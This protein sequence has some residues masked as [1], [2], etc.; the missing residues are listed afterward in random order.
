MRA[1]II[2]PPGPALRRQFVYLHTERFS[3]GRHFPH[4]TAC[5]MLSAL[6]EKLKIPPTP[7]N[8]VTYRLSRICFSQTARPQNLQIA[9]ASFS[10]AMHFIINLPIR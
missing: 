6:L 7:V 9:R 4:Q 10:Q 3:C 1:L 5:S 2:E 8:P